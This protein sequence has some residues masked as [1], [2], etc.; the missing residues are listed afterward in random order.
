MEEKQKQEEAVETPKAEEGSKSE[1]D[2]VQIRRGELAGY[3]TQLREMKRALEEFTSQK[4]QE[5]AAKLKAAQD[6]E[7]L[8]KKT[9]A[10]LE[11]LKAEL[12]KTRRSALTGQARSA[13]LEAGMSAGLVVDGA[14]STLPSDIDADAIPGWLEDIRSRHPEA[15]TKPSNP[16]SAPSAGTV[17]RPTGDQAQVLRAKVAATKGK[18]PT[19]MAAVMREVAEYTRLNGGKNPLA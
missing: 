7:A 9:T 16:I 2:V 17:G 5:E 15:F 10:E 18:G 3:K 11:T 4:A 14:L 12:E 8:N 19:A 6:W 13:L 1:P